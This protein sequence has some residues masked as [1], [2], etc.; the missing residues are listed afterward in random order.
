MRTLLILLL[1]AVS[2]CAAEKKKPDEPTSPRLELLQKQR[3]T[4]QMA[5][6]AANRVR[7]ELEDL[8]NHAKTETERKAYET[9]FQNQQRAINTIGNGGTLINTAILKEKDRLRLEKKKP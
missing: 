7:D 1:T 8:M 9:R 3:T 4:N 2:L 6:N 5:W